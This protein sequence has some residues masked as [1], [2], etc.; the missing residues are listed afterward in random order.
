[1]AATN[2]LPVPQKQAADIEA[3]RLLSQHRPKPAPAKTSS[4]GSSASRVSG[5]KVTGRGATR[6]RGGSV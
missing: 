6:T 1:M 4:N 2:P 5:T 3:A